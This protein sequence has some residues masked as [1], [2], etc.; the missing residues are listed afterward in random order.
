MPP[1]PPLEP[2]PPRSPQKRGRHA[3]VIGGGMAGLLAARILAR[4]FDRVTIVER[5]LV[6][7]STRTRAGLPQAAHAHVLLQAGHELLQRWFPDMAQELSRRGAVSV[8]FGCEFVYAMGAGSLTGVASESRAHGVSRPLLDQA[9]R[10]LLTRESRIQFRNEAQ[11][12]SPL[13]HRGRIAGARLRLSRGTVTELDAD[14]VID[15]SGMGCLSNSWLAPAGFAEPELETVRTCAV[16]VTREFSLPESATPDWK[17]ALIPPSPPDV[18]RA[19]IASMIERRRWQVTLFEYGGS[20][21]SGKPSEFVSFAE[22][23]ARP[24]LLRFLREARP[25]GS[26]R[27]QLCP[28]SIRRRFEH[29]ARYPGGLLPVGDALCAPNPVHAQ[30]LTLAALEARALEETLEGSELTGR[31]LS[32]AYFRRCADV[33]DAAWRFG[34][35]CDLGF[36]RVEAERPKDARALVGSLRALRERAVADADVA[37]R[38]LDAVQLCA[39]LGADR[40]A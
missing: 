2:S 39:P 19:A 15:A 34:N 8:D 26:P 13:W 17:V 3:L 37:R 16:A 22:S 1:P 14:L 28:V 5:D 40:D 21:A 7:A 18:P 25:L 35:L 36:S 20:S 6:E 23:L 31:N 33:I 32:E 27:I 38:L 4:F 10:S 24:E 12:V 11:V 9:V 29:L 30:G